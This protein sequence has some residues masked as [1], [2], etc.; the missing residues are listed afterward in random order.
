MRF[1]G[2]GGQ[3][4]NWR[5]LKPGTQYDY[6]AA[7]GDLWR[8]SAVACCLRWIKV[9]FPEPRVEVIQ[10]LADGKEEVV[11]KS[12]VQRLLH[13]PN[14]FYDRYS[15]DAICSLSY[16]VDGN[17]YIRKV[18][19]NA[20]KVVQL[21]WLPH[22]LVFPRWK[23]DGTEFIGW[24]DYEVN[25]RI[26]RIP[27]DD[28]IHWKNGSDPRDDRRGFS[29]LKQA[30]VQIVGLNEC[31]TYTSAILR[32]MGIV[33]AIISF[34]GDD[35]TIDPKEV[36]ILR[37]QWREDHTSE[38]RGSPLISP[39]GMKVQ[40]LGMSPEEMR[41]DKIPARLEATVHSVVGLSPMVTNADSGKDHRT[42]ANYGEARK[43]AYEDCLI[44]M[45][46]SFAECLTFNL[47][48]KDFAEGDRVRWDYSG[49]KCLAQNETEVA[50][51]VGKQYQTY[52]TITRAEAR[53]MQGL[54]WLPEDE[55][56]F[57]EASKRVTDQEHFDPETDLV[58][59]E[60]I[61]LG[62]G[63]GS[64]KAEA[65]SGEAAPVRS[66]RLAPDYSAFPQPCEYPAT[67]RGYLNYLGDCTEFPDHGF[68]VI[69]D[70]ED[71]MSRFNHCHGKDGR[72]CSAKGGGGKGVKAP[73][74]AGGGGTASSGESS[75]KE[76][77]GKDLGGSSDKEIGDHHKDMDKD[78]RKGLTADEHQ[79][80]RI[81][82][83]ESFGPMNNSLR[84]PKTAKTS[85]KSD[86]VKKVDGALAK[87]SLK[88]DTIVYR[89]VGDLS[90]LGIKGDPA[91]A[92]GQ[93]IK[94]KGY[95][96]TSLNPK[97]AEKY[98]GAAVLRIKAPKGSK[99]ASMGGVSRYP[100]E[101]EVLFAR[102]SGVK[103][104]G[105]SKKGGR[106]IIHAELVQ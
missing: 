55:V 52:Q 54:D 23:S 6:E 62:P 92:I 67:F 63:S 68:E 72:F 46:G 75:H 103:I 59:G 47:L 74:A 60:G 66:F 94:D 29:D 106:T 15:F 33:G 37:D 57:D 18:R 90:K 56:F 7:A 41:L 11:R 79:A 50:E 70:L 83:G 49:I 19:S 8:N 4:Y 81:Y 58:D 102:G 14:P 21:W 104:T 73:S 40:K 97:V 99:G 38:G 61:E 42:Y 76:A 22:W 30:V 77:T 78:W 43:A 26:E 89:G 82:T 39:R 101:H 24:Y 96:S 10:E 65:G 86:L 2:Y 51:R 88:Q 45:Q 53:E 17:C 3:G 84:D 28:I 27:I 105:V 12:E 20:G 95:T 36:D 13:R 32:N 34:E 48:A 87:S 98:D 91:H 9:N 16:V 44:P 1:Q 25:G 71:W 85:E 69:D 100:K 31:D 93:V 80:V 64:A 35:A 5:L